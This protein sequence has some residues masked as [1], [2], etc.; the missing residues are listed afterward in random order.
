MARIEAV[1]VVV[2]G[3][4]LVWD[5]VVGVA[6]AHSA[7]QGCGCGGRGLQWCVLMWWVLWWCAW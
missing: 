4:A 1:G 5:D 3:V 7:H 2:V 6:V